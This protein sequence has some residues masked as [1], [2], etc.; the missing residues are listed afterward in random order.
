MRSIVLITS[1]QPSTNPRAVKEATALINAG[2]EVTFIYSFW[3]SWA[4]TFD[5]EIIKDNPGVKW[6]RAGE[7]PVSN[8]FRYYFSRIRH[9]CFR[10]LNKHFSGNVF[11]SQHSATRYF[12]NLYKLA[13][14]CK[15][16]LYIAHT[17]GALPVAALAAKKNNAKYAFDAED[18]HRG[19]EIHDS[20]EHIRTIILEDKYLPGACYITASSP[21][22]ADL[23]CK[24]YNRTVTVIN[25]VFSKK[26]LAETIK[27]PSKPIKL[28][29]FSQTIGEGRGLEDIIQALKEMPVG[30]FTL[31]LMGKHNE[32]LKNY[33]IDLGKNGKK[34]VDIRFIDPVSSDEIFSIASKHDIGLALETGKDENNSIALSNKIFTYLLS[35][36]AIIFSN[37]SAQKEFYEAN[38]K[39]GSIYESGN[40]KMLLNV[41]DYLRNNPD[42]LKLMKMNAQIAAA[43]KYNWE[44]ENSIFLNTVKK[45]LNA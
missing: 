18:Y 44:M 28:F 12:I 4:L 43:S 39:I 33:F 42:S 24:H 21:L 3:V 16:D 41:L 11:I 2:Y 23:Y 27:T 13:I 34:N 37:T 36:N 40:I 1:G 32:A 17:L 9:K 22:I 29:W 14:D 35:A 5:E 26:Y 10:I 20:I 6:C 38:N 8:K 25:N 45:V 7:T 30:D 15:A 31:T 19:Q